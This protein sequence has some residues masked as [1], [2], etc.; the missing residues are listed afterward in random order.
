M[1]FED[2]NKLIIAELQEMTIISKCSNCAK[3]TIMLAFAQ[4]M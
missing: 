4:M 2:D 1:I 3:C